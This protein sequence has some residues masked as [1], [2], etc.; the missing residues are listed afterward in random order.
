MTRAP[1]IVALAAFA[2]C[3]ADDYRT[4]SR[5]SANLAPLASEVAE[6]IVQVYAARA[7]GWRGLF[8]VHSWLAIKPENA[9]SFQVI[10]VIGFRRRGGG[11]TVRIREDV[12][13]RFW[14]G[15]EP[16]LLQE[17]RGPPAARAIPQILQAV[18]EYAYRGEYRLYPGPNSNTFVSQVLRRVPELSVELPPH[19]VGKDW[20]EGGGIVDISESNTG[21][22]LSLLGVFGTTIGWA[23]GIELDLAG[24][25]FG[26]DLRAPALKLPLIGRLGFPD[27]PIHAVTADP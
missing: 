27:R 5:E 23:E 25:V 12:P 16:T 9:P 20:L 15:A 13:D 7:F 4:A 21:G 3:R 11:D 1:L 17:L 19:A 8:A 24:L 22:Q 26:L 2:A 14:F 10:D 18:D 6:P